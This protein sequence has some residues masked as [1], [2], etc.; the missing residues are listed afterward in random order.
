MVESIGIVADDLTGAVD[1]AGVFASTGMAT[2]VSLSTSAPSPDSVF[3]VLC[4]DTGTRYGAAADAAERVRD[5]T[6]TLLSSG[7]SNLYKKI[8]STLRGHVAAEI[9]AMLDAAKAPFAFVVPAFPATGR[10]QR[11]GVL[12]VNDIPLA[13]SAEGQDKMGRAPTSSVVELLRT[14]SGHKCGLVPLA[15]VESGEA[16]IAA[17]TGALLDGGCAI[18]AFDAI[19]MEHMERIEAV[20]S[21]H[22]PTGLP[23]GS[24]GLASAIAHRIGKSSAQPAPTT[25]SRREPV[26]IVSGSLNTVSLR[27]VD[28]MAVR[29]DIHEIRMDADALIDAPKMVGSELE[30]ILIEIQ[31][32]LNNGL[33]PLLT[34][35]R[36]P[37]QNPSATHHERSRRLNT[38]LSDLM[39]RMGQG[40]RAIGGIV[41]VGGDTAEAVLTGLGAHGI[42]MRSEIMPGISTGTV[43]G[44]DADSRPVIAKAGGFGD[45]DALLKALEYL[46]GEP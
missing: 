1:T 35:L 16:S 7:C 40:V 33:N 23:V 10:T 45:D 5:A 11:D 22:F 38:A 28:Q 12:Y 19:T 34:W 14:Q 43:M 9:V 2:Y 26:L 15:D 30:R 32:A 36:T 29:P 27:Q 24:A 20:L 37:T 46:R 41:L 8:D 25:P 6:R 44:G 18:V 4:V 17:R 13:E 3:E 31:A 39:H 21:G 42:S